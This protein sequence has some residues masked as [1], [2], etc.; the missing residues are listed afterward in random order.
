[1]PSAERAPHLL[2]VFSTFA[3]GGPQTRFA[4]LAN[5]LGGK[6]R[7]TII[8]LDGDIACAGRLDPGIDTQVTTMRLSKGGALHLGNLGRIRRRLAALQPDLLLTYNWGAI[9]WALAQRWRPIVRRHVH[10]EDGFGPDEGAD[11]QLRRRVLFRR[12]ALGGAARIVVPSRT[13]YRIATETW[14]LAPGA[15]QHIVNG[16]DTARFGGPPDPTWARRFGRGGGGATIIGSLGALRAEKNV[17]RL[18][19][20]FAALPTAA[21]ARLVVA[22]DGP[23]APALAALAAALGVADLVDFL[24]SIEQPERLLGNFDIFA[25]SSDTEQMPYALLEAM[26][27]GLPVVATDVGDIAAMVAPDNRR[28][29]VP[30]QDGAGFV[31]RL[32]ELLASPDRRHAL[33]AANRERVGDAFTLDRMVAAYDAVFSD[34]RSR[35]PRIA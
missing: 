7:H 33:G 31:A 21:S 18:I 29:I 5:R 19:R 8:S 20:A 25:L 13:L 22:G 10:L 23:E 28:F 16:V 9:E 11:R 2:H 34:D 17:A 6:Y 1:M 32:A 15:V 14:R 35:G 3:I 24:G 30:Q 12:L 4:T 27:A 26:A